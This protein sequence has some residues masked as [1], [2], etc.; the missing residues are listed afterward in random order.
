MF[1]KEMDTGRDV[2]Y[3]LH[4]ASKRY[5]KMIRQGNVWVVEAII[6]VK[7]DAGPFVGLP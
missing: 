1:D 3:M 5:I 7:D 2:S 6:N 4:K